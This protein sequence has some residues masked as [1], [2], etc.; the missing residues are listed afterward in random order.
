[1]TFIIND[2][3]TSYHK[4]SAN[5]HSEPFD[6]PMAQLIHLTHSIIEVMVINLSLF[7]PWRELS[8]KHRL[9]YVARNDNIVQL[10]NLSF[11]IETLLVM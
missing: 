7:F 3:C 4:C 10:G 11:V 8:K 9:L 5:F 6:Y 1:M 2:Y